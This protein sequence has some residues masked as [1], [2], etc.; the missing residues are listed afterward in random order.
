MGYGLKILSANGSVQLD[1]DQAGGSPSIYQLVARSS[2]SFTSTAPA[3]NG[4]WVSSTPQ[5]TGVTDSSALFFVRPVY[6]SGTNTGS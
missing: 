1:T 3:A 2:G 4:D 5:A 6:G